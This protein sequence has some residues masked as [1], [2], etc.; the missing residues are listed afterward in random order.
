LKSKSPFLRSG[1]KPASSWKL[2]LF[3]PL[4]ILAFIIIE[5]FLPVEHYH[6]IHC[7]LDDLI[8]FCEYF[9]IP[10]VAWYFCIAGVL[11]HL[12]RQDVEN[13]R[14]MMY[15]III[16]TVFAMLTYLLYPNYQNL[17]PAVFPRDNLLTA[18]V[19][20]LYTID[21]NT[22]VCPSMHVMYSFA[23]MSAGWKTHSLKRPAKVFLSVMTVLICL[24]TVFIKQHSVLDFVFAVPCCLFAEWFC[25]NRRIPTTCTGAGKRV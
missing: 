18:L 1:Q 12:L 14:R 8:P 10:Y 11:L 2:L 19:G 6:L 5:R 17:R 25:Y 4:Y 24:S 22:N 20:L 3:W 21:T 15:Y 7:A 9:L 16:T 23:F 13:F